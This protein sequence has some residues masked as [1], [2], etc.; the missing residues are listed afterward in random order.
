MVT[1]Q[2]AEKV[3][4]ENDIANDVAEVTLQ[5]LPMRCI[6]DQSSIS[7]I[8]AFFDSD[9]EGDKKEDW[10]T[11]LHLVPPPRLRSFRVKQW[12]VKVDYIPKTIDFSALREGSF[13][14]LVN[15]NPIDGMV[16][17]LQQVNAENEIGFG[18]VFGSLFRSWVQ[19]I[20]ATQLHK[21][22]THARPFEPFVSVGSGMADLVVLPYEAFKNGE[23]ISR[24]L[25]SGISSLAGTVAFETLTTTSR[26]TQFAA[27]QMAQ[28]VGGSSIQARAQLFAALPSR[29]LETP[30]G[31][32]DVTGHALQSLTQ[33]LQAANYKVV[34][35]PY[36]EFS[37]NGTTGAAKSVLKGIPVLLLAPL[38]GATEALSYT[39][40][41]ARNSLRPD[42][43]REEENILRLKGIED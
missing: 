18:A 3:T 12:R 13:V 11:E 8:R 25:R 29:P 4:G 27:N 23:N 39:L 37:R 42:I 35:V 10:T 7:F 36:R 16:I 28:M 43:R 5:L 31:V 34:I 6:I 20:C 32:A 17:T 38:T 15:L 30:R 14:E 1:W 40:L 33:G 41:G 19:D 9:E 2:P 24:A 26:L 21:F 22:L